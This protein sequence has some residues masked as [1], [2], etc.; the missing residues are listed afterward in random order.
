[1]ETVGSSDIWTISIAAYAAIISTFVLGWDAYKWIASGAK[2]N[3]SVTMDMIIIGGLSEDKNTYIS[4][5]SQ[6]VGDRPTTITNLGGMYYKSW[7]N[8]YLRRGKPDVAFIINSP[9]ENQRIPYRFEVG[10]QW[11]GMAEQT[12]GLSKKA[13]EGYLFFI[14]YTACNRRG[15]RVRAQLK[16]GNEE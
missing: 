9:S 8:A 5:L 7:W 4:V 6:N 13:R 10:D 11:M 15:H 2:L 1:M 16:N 14:L 3:V 12:E